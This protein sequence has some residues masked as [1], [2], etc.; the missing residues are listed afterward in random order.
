MQALTIYVPYSVFTL[1]SSFFSLGPERVDGGRRLLYGSLPPV[2]RNDGWRSLVL[3][4]GH[5]ISFQPQE[6]N[7][8]YNKG[9]I[10]ILQ[11]YIISSE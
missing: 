10:D 11:Q 3:N 8:P 5:S 1:I 9:S 4:R 6:G 7:V 2:P